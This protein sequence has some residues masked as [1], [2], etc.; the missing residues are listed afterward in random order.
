V[1]LPQS[2]GPWINSVRFVVP[3]NGSGN[4]ETIVPSV[5]SMPVGDTRT[6]QALNSSGQP[7]SGLRWSSSD[8]TVASL[9]TDDPPIITAVA[10]GHVTNT[11]GH[12]SAD[13]TVYSSYALPNGHCHLVGAGR[14]LGRQ[15]AGSGEFVP[16]KLG[17]SSY[18]KHPTCIRAKCG[19]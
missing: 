15:Q 11:A 16:F 5:V 2:R 13:L 12:S 7:V 19:R 18:G 14:C 10:T 8:T 3:T 4:N 1:A 17:G 6:L 9:L